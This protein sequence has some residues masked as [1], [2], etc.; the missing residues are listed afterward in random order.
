MPMYPTMSAATTTQPRRSVAPL[1]A[2]LA[3]LVIAALSQRCSSARSAL[4]AFRV[5]PRRRRQPL[6]R[7]HAR[8][9][10]Q[11]PHCLLGVVD[12]VAR[13]DLHREPREERLARGAAE[14]V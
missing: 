2:S 11:E 13:Q 10:A 4:S 1:S 9:P 8:R 5:G 7:A 12:H 14:L 3:P 6:T